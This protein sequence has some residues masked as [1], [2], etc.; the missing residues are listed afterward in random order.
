MRRPVVPR[1]LRAGFLLQLADVRLS[2]C[3][4][5]RSGSAR[6]RCGRCFACDMD[7]AEEMLACGAPSRLH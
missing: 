3:T 5:P 6:P 4:W 7:T 2:D 1:A